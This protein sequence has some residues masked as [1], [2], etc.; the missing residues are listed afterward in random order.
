MAG[1][2]WMDGRMVVTVDSAGGKAANLAALRDSGVRIPPWA[3]IRSDVLDRFL[4]QE[5]GTG[6]AET[7][8]AALPPAFVE[9]VRA[10]YEAAGAGRVAVRSSGLEED[11]GKHSFAGQFDTF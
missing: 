9:V 4:T 6:E 8:D 5:A 3:V 10:A 11:G 2:L 7:G 1:R